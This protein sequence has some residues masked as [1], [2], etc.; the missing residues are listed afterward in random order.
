MPRRRRPYFTADDALTA[1]RIS[2]SHQ[3]SHG[4]FGLMIYTARVLCWNI[5]ALCAAYFAYPRNAA[6]PHLPHYQGGLSE[7]SRLDASMSLITA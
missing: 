4:C 6:L 7:A 3:L 5:A 2:T 1:A